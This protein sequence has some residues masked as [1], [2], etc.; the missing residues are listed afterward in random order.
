VQRGFLIGRGLAPDEARAVSAC[1]MSDPAVTGINDLATMRFGPELLLCAALTFS[2]SLS[3]EELVAA[4]DRIEASLQKLL[5]EVKQIYL[6]ADAL[7]RRSA[8]PEEPAH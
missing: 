2:P 7:A 4:I 5:P 8:P 1:L 6:E 3:S